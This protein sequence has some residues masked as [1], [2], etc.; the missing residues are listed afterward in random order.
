MPRAPRVGAEHQEPPELSLSGVPASRGWPGRSLAEGA[1]HLPPHQLRGAVRGLRRGAAS[2]RPSPSNFSELPR[3]PRDT[4]PRAKGWRA[5]WGAGPGGGGG[6]RH[7]GPLRDATHPARR[8]SEEGAGRPGSPSPAGG[9]RRRRG[10]PP[11]PARPRPARPRLP[12]AAAAAA[13][14]PGGRPLRRRRLDARP[15]RPRPRRRAEPAP[16]PAPPGTH[17]GPWRPRSLA[18]FLPREAQRGLRS[19]SL[20]PGPGAAP[21]PPGREGGRPRR[22]QRSAGRARGRRRRRPGR[23]SPSRRVGARG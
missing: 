22:G 18:S 7:K 5:T 13:R 10:R 23:P 11:G 19:S 15:A 8:A 9:E 2:A 3:P 17:R 20:T 1:L 6:G 21:L 14:L 4:S 12:S 16:S